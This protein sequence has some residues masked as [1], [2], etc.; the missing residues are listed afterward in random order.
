MRLNRFE[1][2][3]RL[4]EYIRAELDFST[5]GNESL[6]SVSWHRAD[7]H[8]CLAPIACRTGLIHARSTTRQ[9][10]INLE[11]LLTLLPA[12][13]GKEWRL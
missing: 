11:W 1:H 12:E 8:G 10:P 6:V 5:D 9:Y 13:V 2:A 3:G 4:H 7:S